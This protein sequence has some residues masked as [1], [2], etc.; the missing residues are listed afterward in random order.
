MSKKTLF[1]YKAIND[2]VAPLKERLKK[3]VVVL[4]IIV[5]LAGL[6]FL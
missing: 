3:Y 2:N 6:A 5:L 4:I 1:N